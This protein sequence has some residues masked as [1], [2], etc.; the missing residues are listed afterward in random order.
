MP[1]RSYA[2]RSYTICSLKY[3]TD[4]CKSIIHFTTNILPSSVFTKNN[5]FPITPTVHYNYTFHTFFGFDNGIYALYV[6][7]GQDLEG[8]DAIK[9]QVGSIDFDLDVRNVHETPVVG[10]GDS[11]VNIGAL[12]IS[13]SGDK[14]V[15]E[16]VEFYGDHIVISSSRLQNTNQLRF[17]FVS[18]N[19]HAMSV[20]SIILHGIQCGYFRLSCVYG[21]S[22]DGSSFD[23]NESSRY[24][25]HVLFPKPSCW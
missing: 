23:S 5:Q 2:S 7:V 9:V 18:R 16:N 20:T 15:L 10:I 19:A 4:L 3:R 1:N 25:C 17:D 6:S 11:L 8:G 14:F 24:E 12:N 13:P 21:D 22:A